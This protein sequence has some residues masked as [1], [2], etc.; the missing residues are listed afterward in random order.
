MMEKKHYKVI[1]HLKEIHYVDAYS[2]EDAEKEVFHQNNAL[3]VE[4]TRVIVKID[5]DE[6]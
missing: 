3:K 1:R 2:K 5:K 6:N 4:I